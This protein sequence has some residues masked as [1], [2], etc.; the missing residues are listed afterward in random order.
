MNGYTFDFSVVVTYREAIL[1]GLFVTVEL[2]AI[3]LI[4]GTA[5]G[6]I[7]ALGKLSRNGIIKS[8][9]SLVI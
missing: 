3:S 5:I 7:L 2:A 1:R 4:T 9:S 6:L 8:F